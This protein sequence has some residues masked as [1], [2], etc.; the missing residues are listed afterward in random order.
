[1]KFNWVYLLVGAIFSHLIV[2]AQTVDVE[3]LKR[4]LSDL[5]KR[6]EDLEQKLNALQSQAPQSTNV[7]ASSSTASSI[8]P[9]GAQ[10][11][12]SP[13][14]PIRLGS[15]GNSYLDVA[16][17]ALV[18]AGTS[19]AEDV[20]TLNPGGHDPNQRGFTLQSLETTFTGIVDPYLRG[21]ANILF[22]IDSEGE[23]NVELEE[24]Y[25]E[26]L[27]LPANLQ[28]RAGQF[29]TEFGRHN[30]THPHAWQ[31]VDAPL[32][33]S[34]FFGADGLRNPGARLSWLVPTPFYSM[35]SLAVQNSQG[36]T[37]QSFRN[38]H[39]D[40][41]Y[42]GRLH[43]V[44]RVKSLNDLLFTPRFEISFE[45]T[46]T[47]VLLLGSS[48]SFGPNASG[49]H[50]DTEIYGVDLF[51]KWKPTKHTKGFPF[52]SWQ[53]EAMLR[54][55]D[56]AEFTE[57]ID[58]DGVPDN[59]LNGDTVADF[60]PAEQL[61]D[62]GFYS[63][64]AYGFTP[65][66]V[67]AVRGDWVAPKDDGAYEL[68]YGPDAERV[69]RWRLSPNI[70]WYPSEFSKIR[71]QYNLDDRKGLGMDHSIWLQFEFLLGAH[72]AHRF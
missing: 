30:P 42:L 61:T 7:T 3:A 56:A 47:Q 50:S 15:R 43:S 38:S 59:D 35:L 6:T 9:S 67:A 13:T 63:Q 33:N 11:P 52:V 31:F 37:A 8:L 36:E 26:T 57:D 58:G 64:V 2:S 55:Y 28:L 20:E 72:G 54:Q 48:A 23:S 16:V 68:I 32:V 14:D 45:P 70:T 17:D 1:M 24:A 46:V 4:E 66:W 44:E 62:Y 41:P 27:S 10:K 60:I 49:A 29:L 18:A 51:W 39:E 34:R 65:G 40:E 19:T 5:R 53:T 12:W 21:Q 25:L 71:L 22:F 69:E